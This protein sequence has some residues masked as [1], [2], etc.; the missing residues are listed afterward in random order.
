MNAQPD[1]RILCPCCGYDLFSRFHDAA[2]LPGD[3]STVCSECFTED[4]AD[5]RCPCGAALEDD[6]ECTTCHADPGATGL[7][8]D[9]QP[10]DQWEF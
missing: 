8:D 1:E 4:M 5:G 7:E 3:G 6:G 10:P 9:Y 2:D